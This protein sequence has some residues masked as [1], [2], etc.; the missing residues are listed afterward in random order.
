MG[1]VWYLAEVRGALRRTGVSLNRIEGAGLGVAWGPEK[2]DK[3]ARGGGVWLRDV[4]L[5]RLVLRFSR[6]MEEGRSRE[7]AT[8]E[9]VEEGGRVE[10][11][12]GFSRA[13]EGLEQTDPGLLG[14]GFLFGLFREEAAGEAPP[15]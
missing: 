8:V 14:A 11:V 15:E 4:E 7:D 3:G 10:E 2:G 1:R 9:V 6:G 12:G 13:A 5:L